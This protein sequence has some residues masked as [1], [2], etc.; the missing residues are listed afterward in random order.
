MR[1]RRDALRDRVIVRHRQRCRVANLRRRRIGMRQYE[2][3][4]AIGERRLA[5]ARRPADQPGVGHAAG[6]IRVEHHLLGLGV[7]DE[8][9]HL[10]RVC[11]LIVARV[12]RH[13]EARPSSVTGAVAGS[14]R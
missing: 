4:H 1:L 3:R 5:D 13:H 8:F 14:S 9:A 10:A 12:G 7:T 11:K 6:A 2:A